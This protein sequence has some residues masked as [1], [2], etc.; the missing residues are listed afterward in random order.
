MERQEKK[1]KGQI[2]KKCNKMEG[3]KKGKETKLRVYLYNTKITDLVSLLC[4]LEIDMGN[5]P[6]YRKLFVVDLKLWFFFSL[7]HQNAMN[8]CSFFMFFAPFPVYDFSF[9]IKLSLK[10]RNVRVSFVKFNI[11]SLKFVICDKF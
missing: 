7:T 5:T 10:K 1:Q 11:T 6:K 3:K 8:L 4:L 2:W 9:K